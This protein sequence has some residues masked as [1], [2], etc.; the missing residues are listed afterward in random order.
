M[1]F[2]AQHFE[3]GNLLA[4]LD[5]RMQATNRN[6]FLC[7]PRERVKVIKRNAFGFRNFDNFRT[8]FSLPLTSKKEKKNF[9]LSRC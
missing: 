3:S 6:R 1:S 4:V 8:R 2:V 9:S 7:Y 5:G